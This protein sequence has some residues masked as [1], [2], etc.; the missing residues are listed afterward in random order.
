MDFR[1]PTPGN[2]SAKN[3]NPLSTKRSANTHRDL[4]SNRRSRAFELFGSSYV[5]NGEL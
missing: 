5:R 4:S 3:D 2:P 1:K